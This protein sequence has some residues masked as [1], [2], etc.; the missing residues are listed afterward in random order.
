M[1]NVNTRPADDAL[2]DDDGGL[3]GSSAAPPPAP[4]PLPSPPASPGSPLTFPP[5]AP[6]EPL[7][8]TGPA[9]EF[10]GGWASDP[11][12]AVPTVIAWAHGG[13]VVEVEGSWDGW[14]TRTP[15]ARTAR[16]AAAVVKMLPP[17]VYQYK[18]VVDGVWRY[19]PDAAAAYDE[20]GNVNNVVDVRDPPPDVLD[21]LAAFDAPPSPPASYGAAPPSPD[22]C[23]K[24]PPTLPPHLALTL[25][26]VPAAAAAAAAAAAGALPCGGLPRPQHVVLNHLYARRGDSGGGGGGALAGSSGGGAS[27]G[28]GGP[29]VLGTTH[30]FRGK[31]VTTVLY[32]PRAGRAAGDA[33]GV[34]AG[35]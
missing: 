1:G 2:L 18:F 33:G 19:A 17:G 34:V 25:L 11:S 35:A 28:Y 14:A 10:A 21:G 15:L 29:A 31:F 30:R 27:G 24:E 20:A 5:H 22:D 9:P 6:S 16:G 8:P 23:A 32:A 12:R 3:G 4:R 26:N 13:A 7:P